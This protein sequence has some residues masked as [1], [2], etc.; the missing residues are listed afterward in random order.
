MPAIVTPELAGVLFDGIQIGM[1]AVDDDP[2]DASDLKWLGT[3]VSMGELGYERP[4]VLNTHVG[5]ATAAVDFQAAYLVSPIKNMKQPTFELVAAADMKLE[6]MIET[7]GKQIVIRNVVQ[8]GFTTA[9]V[10]RLMAEI[11]SI[12]ESGSVGSRLMIRVTLSPIGSM[13]TTA[14]TPD[15]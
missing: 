15:A 9:R 12:T 2:G 6:D 4:T 1:C 3:V 10:Q 8:R 13:A 11:T 5:V 7:Q 14:G